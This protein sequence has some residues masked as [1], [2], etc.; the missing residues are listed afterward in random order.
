MTHL[1]VYEWKSV[2]VGP[3]DKQ[4]TRDQADAIHSAACAHAL[5]HEGGINVLV[6]RRD[7]LL[8]RQMVGIV[9]A[10]APSGGCSLEIL[11]KVDPDLPEPSD[12][13]AEAYERQSVRAR[14]VRML[15][16][17]LGLKLDLGSS[18]AIARQNE[19]LLE[20]L[21]RHFADR[22]L[23]E[24]R[25]GL[26]RQYIQCQDDLPALHGRLDVVR[27]F[28]RNAVRPDRLACRFDELS[29]DTPL[30]RIM[31]AASLFLSKH[32]RSPD[33][34][35]KLL[36][37]QHA[38]AHIPQIP[39]SRLPWKKVRTDRTNRRWESLF[40]LAKLLLRRDYQSTHHGASAPQ[41]L[42]LLFPMNDLFEAYVAALLRRALAGTG[43][44]VTEQGGRRNCLA[45][46]TGEVLAHTS[47]TLFQTKP[48]LLLCRDGETLAIVDTKWKKLGVDP[49]ERKHG[50]AQSDIY[51]MMAYARL[52]RC[53]EIALLYPETPGK[54]R[55]LPEHLGMVG[56][57][58]RLSLATLDVSLPE[59]D[60]V[61]GLRQFGLALAKMNGEITSRLPTRT[62]GAL[63]RT[64][65]QEKM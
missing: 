54:C 4:F 21:I 59:A 37:L 47:G 56:G 45:E 57:S 7:A 34:L 19:T 11:P 53:N 10:D 16:V 18:A 35:R 49:T 23:A 61:S 48:D 1:S 30:M 15:D 27:Q 26:P 20:I 12:T 24:V 42:T 6:Y 41:G 62:I 58:E 32:A 2:K 55:N 44:D 63:E 52:Y 22:L 5:A 33:T 64:V 31:A 14:L 8:A 3:G 51:Q 38:F 43:I 46:F 39:V 13:E 60:L 29:A 40:A 9:A 28:A 65:L 36:E 25:R 50:V 17:A